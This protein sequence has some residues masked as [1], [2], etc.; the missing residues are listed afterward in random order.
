MNVERDLER[1]LTDL[2]S[3]EANVRAPDR[4][5][6]NALET[7]DNTNQ[8]RRLIRLRETGA[9]RRVRGR[10]GRDRTG[11]LSTGGHGSWRAGEPF[12]DRQSALVPYAGQ[13]RQ[14]RPARGRPVCADRVRG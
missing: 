6:S 10:R 8:R 11:D 14:R 1:R 9:R 5:L 7:V 13:Q 3:A 4:V 2:Y 12:A